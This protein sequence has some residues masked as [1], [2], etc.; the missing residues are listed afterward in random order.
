MVS[1]KEGEVFDALE[2]EEEVSLEEEVCCGFVD[3]L[4]FAHEP[5]V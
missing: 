2:E 3:V 5:L 1:L 4:S